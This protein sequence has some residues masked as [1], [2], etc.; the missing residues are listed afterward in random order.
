VEVTA[1]TPDGDG[2]IYVAGDFTAAGGMPAKHVARWNGTGWSPLG[3]GIDD[4]ISALAVWGG[5]LYAAGSFTTAG[6]LSANHIARWNGSAWSPLGSGTDGAVSSIAVVGNRLFVGGKFSKAGGN[7]ASGVAEWN[8]STWSGVGPEYTYQGVKTVGTVGDVV[9]LASDG[10]DL[11]VAGGFIVAGGVNAKHVARWDGVA[12]HALG[13]GIDDTVQSLLFAGNRLYAGTESEPL[14]GPF[15]GVTSWDGMSWT[16][17]GEPFGSVDQNG[18]RVCALGALGSDLYAGGGIYRII[19]GDSQESQ[20]QLNA[21]GIARWDGQSWQPI[22]APASGGT[23]AIGGTDAAIYLAQGVGL[24]RSILRFAEDRW[25]TIGKPVANTVGPNDAV[26]TALTTTATDLYVG[27]FFVSIDGIGAKNIARFTGFTWE[28]LGTGLNAPNAFS[29]NPPVKALAV[30]GSQLY[31]GGNFID[32]GG[33]PVHNIARWDG[34]AWATLGTGTNGPVLALAARDDELFAVGAFSMAG[35]VTAN[36][37]ARWDGSAWSPVGAGIP[38]PT[39]F[40]NY[41]TGKAALTFFGSDLYVLFQNR[42]RNNADTIARW[43]GST[44][45]TLDLSFAGARLFA[46]V[47]GLAVIGPD[48]YIGGAFTGVNDVP[49]HNIARWNGV[50]WSPLGSGVNDAVGHLAAN[51]TDLILTGAFTTAGGLP[52]S[53]FAIWHTT[54]RP[55]PTQTPTRLPN[56][57]TPT[58]T[59]P[60]P[61]PSGPRC[62]GDCDGG[63]TVTVDELVKGVSI[64][65]GNAL[66]AECPQFDANHDRMVTVDEL[67]AGVNAAL[68]GC[69]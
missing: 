6:G 25:Q 46:A 43:D 52:S 39:T 38:L 28:P 67:I 63:G 22:G 34:A 45:T 11:Y 65:L 17:V 58:R 44:W 61:T 40:D 16:P 12:W 1:I 24:V 30:A 36:Q 48:L 60:A 51:G 57:P 42:Q 49:A 64:A 31:A 33:T 69:V 35:G 19:Q 8:G 9:A 18:D 55:T 66:L 68:N 41:D 23:T 15:F 21:F 14:S 47:S 20:D 26:I 7:S 5:D 2:G 13:S 3:D 27:G 37:I 53:G 10:S 56:T 29:H 54:P 59:P 62:T 4:G 50:E 32:A